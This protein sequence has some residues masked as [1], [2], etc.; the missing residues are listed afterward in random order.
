MSL[1]LYINYQQSTPKME[2]NKNMIKSIL[3]TP[4][5]SPF[6]APLPPANKALLVTQP[7]PRVHFEKMA[8]S[9]EAQ[10][11]FKIKKSALIHAMQAKKNVRKAPF[12]ADFR[13][14]LRNFTK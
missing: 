13:A 3:S 14:T 4:N 10:Q 1:Q 6:E 8:G 2:S 7:K 12:D 9:E 11:S 5:A